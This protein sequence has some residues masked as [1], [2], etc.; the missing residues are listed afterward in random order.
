M[1][2]GPP[3]IAN[4]SRCSVV[5]LT[6][7]VQRLRADEFGRDLFTMP[8][9]EMLLDLYTCKSRQ[10]RSLTALTGASSA[11]ERNSQ[12]IVHRMAER[13]LVNLRRDPNDGRRIL[14]ELEPE[15]TE[16]LDRFFDRMVEL[17][18]VLPTREPSDR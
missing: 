4:V 17:F 6:E 16:L 15:A 2:H 18:A 11:S 14:V 5:D 7:Q 1:M 9:F 12:R 8:A 13:G 3:I 10:P